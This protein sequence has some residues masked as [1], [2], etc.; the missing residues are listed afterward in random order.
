MS[1]QSR[2]NRENDGFSSSDGEFEEQVESWR[3]KLLPKQV[4]RENE[5]H[6]IEILEKNDKIQQLET[7]IAEQE[8][9]I[10]RLEEPERKVKELEEELQEQ[11][12]ENGKLT[13]ELNK[14][15][16]CFAKYKKDG[17]YTK[18]RLQGKVQELNNMKA[19]LKLKT[20][21]L[22][23]KQ[24][25]N[26]NLKKELNHYLKHSS[27]L[28]RTNTELLSKIKQLS[29]NN[30]DSGINN[31]ANMAS[32]QNRDR[33]NP[34]R[35]T[36]DSRQTPVT[37]FQKIRTKTRQGQDTDRAVHRLLVPSP[38]KKKIKFTRRKRWFGSFRCNCGRSWS[39][40]Y[41]WTLDDEPQPMQ[42]QNCMTSVLPDQLVSSIF[43]YLMFVL[44][45]KRFLPINCKLT[46]HFRR[47]LKRT[48]PIKM[49]KI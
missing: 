36:S 7:V 48:I 6:S 43:I 2:E 23:E 38:P 16:E 27:E 22:E 29:E 17:E 32:Q 33:Q 34:D 8:K 18:S 30:N 26:E 21:K 12:E 14:T 24:L 49:D 39:S 25:E 5:E 11:R 45:K 28:N 41:T 1:E 37:I 15:K 13:D 47:S 4:R 19:E 35:K 42:C 3:V 9:N 44:I 46:F 31:G 20:E 40:G 10:I